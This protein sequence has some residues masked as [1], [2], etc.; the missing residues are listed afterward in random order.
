VNPNL[1]LA[2]ATKGGTSTLHLWLRQHPDI[3]MTKRKELHYFCSCPNPK[4]RAAANLSEYR[5]LFSA[6]NVVGESSPCY[7]YYPE[8]PARINQE[9]PGARILVSLRDP[10]ARFWSHYL[11]NEAYRPRGMS[12]DEILD[13]HLDD[14]RRDAIHDLYGV[15][16]YA[17][18]LTRW[19][20]VFGR[21]RML[22]VFLEDMILDPGA[23][24]QEVFGFLSLPPATI[25]TSIRD[26]EYVEPR[27]VM[28]RIA[29]RQPLARRIG[30]AV[31][32]A[33]AR[34]ILRTRVLGDASKKPQ[35]PSELMA[36]LRDLYRS[37]SRQL[38]RLLGKDLPWDWHNQ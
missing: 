17:E 30:N 22:I 1:F 14:G 19:F 31:V 12:A 38:E 32:P 24:L 2:G 4:L 33:A 15:G 21:E 26:K 10:V 25:D 18:Q 13:E 9:F 8:T 29:L 6:G 28:G 5:R 7:L 20:A 37:D 23:V 27:G 35:M 16:L 34:R 3:A 36:R 11:M